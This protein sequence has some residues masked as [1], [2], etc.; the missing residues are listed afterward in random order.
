MGVVTTSISPSQTAAAACR[1][2]R[3]AWPAW[4]ARDL[5]ARAGVIRRTAWLLAERG[6]EMAD[7]IVEATARPAAEIWSA[8]IVPT[9]DALRWLAR[10]GPAALRSRRLGSSWLQW[11]FRRTRHALSWE[12]FGV[13]GVVTPRNSLLF[14]SLPQIAAALLAGNG[15][16]WKPAPGGLVVATQAG[17]LFAR[18][19]LPQ[20]VL[21]IVPGGAET[22]RGVVEAGVDK[23]FFTGS[24]AAGQALYRLQAEGGRPAVLEL[25]GLHAA[26]VLADADLETAARAIAW[27]KAANQGRNCVSV[28][29]VL[30]E[31]TVAGA[32]GSLVLAA[33]RSQEAVAIPARCEP[34]RTARLRGLVE[35]AV[36]KGATLL[37]G[38]GAGPTLI[39]G[40]APGMRIVEE[41]VHGPILA[42]AA[43]ASGDEAVRWINGGRQRLSASVWSGNRSAARRLAHRLDVGMVWIN[44]ELHPTAQPEVPL[45]GRGGSGFG[46][47]RGRPGLLEMVQPKVVSETA[48]GRARP[49]Y[50]PA[51]VSAVAMFRHTAGL[52]SARGWGGRLREADRLMRTLLRMG[53]ER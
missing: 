18:A 8:E 35:D 28:Q 24:S 15:V 37:H 48:G 49:Y 43:V 47:S 5:A 31:R 10:S 44:E 9:L 13:L 14:L 29:L 50:R 27:N 25:S 38:D 46:A 7:L 40:V 30:A 11:Y 39:A 19:G 32:F 4:A 6:T 2:A 1:A 20:D 26:V 16:V 42:L 23:L 12:P 51:G 22:A 53:R 33:T 17:A 3:A 34:E 36:A 45:A 41:E 52:G 21:Q